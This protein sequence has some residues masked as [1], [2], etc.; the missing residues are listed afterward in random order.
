M[1]PKLARPFILSKQST[2]RLSFLKT[3]LKQ[4]QV[5]LCLYRDEVIATQASASIYN[6]QSR[7]HALVMLRRR[8]NIKGIICAGN[9]TNALHV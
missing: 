6:N 2:S 7:P 4:R 1:L 3:W 5:Q 8:N 9:V